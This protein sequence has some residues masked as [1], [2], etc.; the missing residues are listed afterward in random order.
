MM[1]TCHGNTVW[2]NTL[3]TVRSTTAGR[4]FVGII[5]DN[6]AKVEAVAVRTRISGQFISLLRRYYR[7]RIWFIS[8]TATEKPST[9]ITPAGEREAISE[10]DA[11]VCELHNPLGLLCG[12]V[13]RS[14]LGK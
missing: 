5:T 3:S 11:V 7:P 2:R 12:H 9:M 13:L 4:Y 8:N 14:G 1:I 6:R 10:E